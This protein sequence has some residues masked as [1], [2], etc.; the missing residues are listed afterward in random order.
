MAR[1]AD[2]IPALR[3]L[4]FHHSA[5]QMTVFFIS[6]T[7]K[8]SKQRSASSSQ[9]AEPRFAHH[10]AR[11][12]AQQKRSAGSALVRADA[13]PGPSGVFVLLPRFSPGVRAALSGHHYGGRFQG[14]RSTQANSHPQQ[15]LG[16]MNNARAT[17]WDT[18]HHRASTTHEM[19][20]VAVSRGR[21]AANR[22]LTAPKPSQAKISQHARGRLGNP[23]IRR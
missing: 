10:R 1:V 17:L 2:D 5:Q 16:K 3:I 20:V 7:R 14:F 11:S 6:L 8:M 15:D 22:H 23:V 9:P 21:R 4:L 18:F 13:F 19:L 12:T